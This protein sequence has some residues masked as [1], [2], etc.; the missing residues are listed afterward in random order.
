[1]GSSGFES[2]RPLDEELRPKSEPSLLPPP[3][4]DRWILRRDGGK[5]FDLF[6]AVERGL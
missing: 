5:R 4:G 1:M 6:A 2:L 3:F